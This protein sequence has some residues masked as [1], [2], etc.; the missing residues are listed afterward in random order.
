M[1]TKYG[2]LLTAHLAVAVLMNFALMTSKAWGKVVDIPPEPRPEMTYNISTHGSFSG[3]ADVKSS[4]A[5]VSMTN[6]GAT[7]DFKYFYFGYER[8]SFN[9]DN[10]EEL[11]LGSNRT[12]KPW[13]DLNTLMIGT[14]YPVELTDT[15]MLMTL[16]DISANYENEISG[17]AFAYS[18]MMILNYQFNDNLVLAGGAGVSKDGVGWSAFPVIRV[19]YTYED[20][21]IAVGF[22][23]AEA[24]YTINNEWAV[25]AAYDATGGLYKLDRN[26]AA[27]KDGFVDI[28]QNFLG[29]YADWSP[30]EH[31][32]ISAGP[33][34]RFAGY[35][36]MYDND[37]DKVGKKAKLKGS[38]GGALTL[39]Y[40]F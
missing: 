33:E 22:P 18:G 23:N 39:Q 15:L 2:K 19:E 38:L 10:A 9:W 36:Q 35:M 12:S 26:N 11:N 28:S 4:D 1:Q 34:Y 20:W 6:Y 16:L 30:T 5:S 37:G 13:D 31:F 40:N 27:E 3:E 7:I 17:S 29:L 8:T 25:R 14:S 24:T 32:Y 21:M